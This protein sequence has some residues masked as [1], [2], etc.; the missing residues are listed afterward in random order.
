MKLEIDTQEEMSVADARML[1][2]LIL[3]KFE[4][5]YPIYSEEETEY[6]QVFTAH[7]LEIEPYC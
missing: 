7:T 6:Y 3:E 1:L 4:V 2:E 5:L